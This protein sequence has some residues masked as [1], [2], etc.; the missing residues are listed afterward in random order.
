MKHFYIGN[1]KINGRGMIAGE[2]I[3]KGEMINRVEG[4]LRFQANNSKKESLSHPNWIGVKKDVWIDP[5][6]PHKFLN[7]SC[8]PSAGVRGLT[9][10]AIQDIGEGEEIT[11]DYST[12][13]G[14]AQWEMQCSCGEKECRKVIRSIQYLPPAQFKRIPY[15]PAYFRNL[16]LESRKEMYNGRQALRLKHG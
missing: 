13:E 14:D 5:K 3:Q 4:P 12:V 9:L 6:R 10:F 1:S 11:I 7:H 15:I 2:N 16:Y 8:R